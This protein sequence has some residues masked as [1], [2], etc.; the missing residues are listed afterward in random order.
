MRRFHLDRTED[1][2]GISGTGTVA[3]G[4]VFEDGATVLRWRGATPSTVLYNKLEDMTH[5]HLHGGRTFITWLDQDDGHP[6]P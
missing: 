2:N 3:D 1:I 4:V 5:V 6:T